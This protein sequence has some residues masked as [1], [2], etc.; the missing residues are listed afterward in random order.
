MHVCMTT[1]IDINALAQEIKSFLASQVCFQAVYVTPHN[2]KY[3]VLSAS[4]NKIFP[5]FLRHVMSD[6][7][8]QHLKCNISISDDTFQPVNTFV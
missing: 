3:N 8:Q 7:L 6:M 4:L 2:R 5:P 1:Y